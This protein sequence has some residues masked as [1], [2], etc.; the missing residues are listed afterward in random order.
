MIEQGGGTI[1][2]ILSVAARKIFTQSSAY[3]ASK[4]GLLGYT[5]VLREEVKRT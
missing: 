2:N 4:M 1:I 5:N 3:A